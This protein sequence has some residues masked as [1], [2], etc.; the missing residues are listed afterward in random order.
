M[1]QWQQ[2]EKVIVPG[3][4]LTRANGIQSCEMDINDSTVFNL[5]CLD[6]FSLSELMSVCS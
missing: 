6:G 1:D 4:W 5:F 3:C 2:E